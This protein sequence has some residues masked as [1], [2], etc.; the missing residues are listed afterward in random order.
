[1][2]TASTIALVWTR[3]QC[4]DSC[5]KQLCASCH[6]MSLILLPAYLGETKLVASIALN[7]AQV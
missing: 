2:H 4:A 5:H 1:M 6:G 7:P 3:W